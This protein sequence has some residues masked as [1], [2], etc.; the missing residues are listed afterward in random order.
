MAKQKKNMAKINRQAEG[1]KAKER[2]NLSHL[3]IVLG[4]AALIVAFIGIAAYF[5][6]Q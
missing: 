3:Y 6:A 5:Y 2:G 1:K 4:A